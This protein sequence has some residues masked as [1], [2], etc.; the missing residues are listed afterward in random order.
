MVFKY[1]TI[2]HISYIYGICIYNLNFYYTAVLSKE[3]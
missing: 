3:L 2:Q 1:F